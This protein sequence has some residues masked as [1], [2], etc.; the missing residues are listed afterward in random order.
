MVLRPGRTY[1]SGVVRPRAA[2]LLLVLLPLLALMPAL[3]ARAQ[4]ACTSAADCDDGNECTTDDC[5]VTSTCTHVA[6]DG[7]RCG[8]ACTDGATCQ[9]G[10]CDGGVPVPECIPCLVNDDCEDGSACTLDTCDAGRCV[11]QSGEGTACDD[12]DP[13]TVD[14]RC[15]ADV[16]AGTALLCDDGVACTIDSCDGGA[17]TSEADGTLCPAA[18]E[19]AQSE[20]RPGD[21]AAN[22]QGCVGESS[23]FELAECTEDDN[24]CTLDHCRAGACAHE[25]VD[26]PQGCLPLVP[27]YRRAVGLR[28]GVERVL[29]YVFDEADASGD[30]GDGL[31][32]QL[33]AIAAELDAAI[34][35]LAGREAS[36]ELPAGALRGLRLAATAT[37]AQQRGYLALGWLRGTPRRVQRFKAMVSRGRRRNEIEP[38]PAHELRRNGRILLV[39]TKLLKRDVKSLQKT[40]R[41]FQR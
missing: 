27:S 36:A 18:T 38:E 17:C 23:Q 32:E 9:A 4:E 35:V 39:E 7:E 33:E 10:V 22:A 13:C 2:F 5:A 12:E 11:Q 26:D 24:P 29:T 31:V 20:C 16:C 14:D 41:V 30:T 6:L 34:R 8:D 40:F 21:P 3:P 25:A 28:G 19:C 1:S 15:T 37:T